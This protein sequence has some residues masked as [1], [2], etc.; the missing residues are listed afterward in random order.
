[1]TAP[2]KRPRG[3]QQRA[4]VKSTSRVGFDVTPDEFADINRL[5]GKTPRA[6][7]VR[8]RFYTP[9]GLAPDHV[10][11]IL[12]IWRASCARAQ[13]IDDLALVTDD[14]L[15]RWLSPPLRPVFAACLELVR[16]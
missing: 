11:T 15:A 8:Q 13:G 2:D 7:Y 10:R 12:G 3:R 1:M 14:V 4:E 5:R 16:E 9:P 6:V